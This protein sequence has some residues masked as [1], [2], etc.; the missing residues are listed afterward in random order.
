MADGVQIDT[1]Q[2][3]EFGQ[4]LRQ[5][6]DGG[7]ASAVDRCANLHRH[8]VVFG[9]KITAGPIQ[10]AK[11]RYAEAL[12]NTDAN[13]RAYHQAAGILADV[14]EQIAKDFAGTDLS[15]AQQQGKVDEMISGAIARAQAVMYGPQ[16]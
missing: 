13:L 1:D 7:F 11:I 3:G 14:A 16:L 6:A 8:G 4:G 9:A 12:E 5:E 15:S 2:V 10:D